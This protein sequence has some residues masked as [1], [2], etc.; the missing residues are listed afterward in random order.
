MGAKAILR[1]FFEGQQNGQAYKYTLD[2]KFRACET[3]K[4]SFRPGWVNAS[5]T[6][7]NFQRRSFLII[8]FYV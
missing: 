1:H 8:F 2:H 7:T 4:K 5:L 6:R 3:K